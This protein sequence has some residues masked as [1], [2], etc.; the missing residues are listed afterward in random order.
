[1]HQCRKDVVHLKTKCICGTV[2]RMGDE[3][4][5]THGD[6]RCSEVDKLIAQMPEL[7]WSGEEKRGVPERRRHI[8]HKDAAEDGNKNQKAGRS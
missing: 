7:G 5:L 2:H 8:R 6:G 1:M 4:C 3:V